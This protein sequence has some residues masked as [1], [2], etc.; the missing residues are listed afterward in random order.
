MCR[1]PKS[2]LFTGEGC[3]ASALTEPSLRLEPPS[4]L[5]LAWFSVDVAVR[6]V[7]GRG[8]DCVSSEKGSSENTPP[9][10]LPGNEGALSE[11][12]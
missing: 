10:R 7:P 1:T 5:T 6:E 4:P 3:R 11:G 8:A 9:C 12:E 2:R